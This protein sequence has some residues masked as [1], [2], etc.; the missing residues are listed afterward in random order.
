MTDVH[1]AVTRSRNMQAIRNKDTKPE[2][3]IRQMLHA[4][5]F[6]YR[7]NAKDLPGRPD[8]VFPRYK[9]VIQVNG[10]FWH[11]HDCYV[12][13]WPKTRTEFWKEKITG[14][15]VRDQCSQAIL[16]DKGWKIMTVWECAL[17]GK[18]KLP[19]MVVAD[20]IE[21]WLLVGGEG[22]FEVSCDR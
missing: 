15:Q 4:R 16:L 21:N 18:K 12:F 8:I 7:L 13:R 3:I 10:C 2:L 9:A 5:G 17:K 20:L 11:G 6:R 14:N 1:D 22:A 19:V